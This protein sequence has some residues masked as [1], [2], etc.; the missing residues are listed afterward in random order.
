MGHDAW[1]KSSDLIALL[2]VN[3]DSD[4]F[5][6]LHNMEQLYGDINLSETN[7]QL[8]PISLHAAAELTFPAAN[9][10]AY[11][12]N[13]KGDLNIY[14]NC[15]GLSGV[16]S[17]LPQYWSEQA[18]SVTENSDIFKAFLNIFQ[19][20]LY[21]LYYLSW[22]INQPVILLEQH[23]MSYLK[24]LC[25]LSGQSLNESYDQEFAYTGLFGHRLHNSVALSSLLNG[26]L[27]GIR[28]AVIQFIPKWVRL[29]DHSCLGGRQQQS[30]R[31]NDNILLGD[32][33]MSLSHTI[34]IQ[35]GPVS[36]E[37]AYILLLDQ[38]PLKKLRHIIKLYVGIIYQIE[39]AIHVYVEQ[40]ECA[41]LASHKIYLGWSS[42]L[43]NV[44]NKL[45]CINFFQ[46]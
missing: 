28:V 34:L 9:I 14:L 11:D 1:I 13:E 7:L 3:A 46:K 24:Y 21:V 4:L 36:V 8:L 17:P 39:I 12:I 5:V 32:N 37:N 25:A 45:F 15:L 40:Q 35:L 27:V 29:T 26:Y 44:K 31:L 30:L 20:R 23:K 33:I 41:L 2:K 10:R 19:Q 18:C 43:G 42:L 6:I 22:K 38:E 16:D